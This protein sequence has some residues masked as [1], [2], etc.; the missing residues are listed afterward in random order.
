VKGSTC[1]RR[2]APEQRLATLLALLIATAMPGDDTRFAAPSWPAVE[3]ARR[4]P[5]SP[6]HTAAERAPGI[7]DRFAVIRLS[8]TAAPMPTTTPSCASASRASAV[9]RP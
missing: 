7:R 2:A 8:A 3:R 4:R 5:V 6:P 9:L 1:R